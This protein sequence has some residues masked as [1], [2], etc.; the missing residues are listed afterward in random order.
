M[1]ASAYFHMCVLCRESLID[2]SVKGQY[3]TPMIRT[4]CLGMCRKREENSLKNAVMV[5]LSLEFVEETVVVQ[6]LP[7]NSANIIVGWIFSVLVSYFKAQGLR[8]IRATPVV[9]LMKF[10]VYVMFIFF[11]V[12][13]V[14]SSSSWLIG[15]N[16]LTSIVV[17]LNVYLHQSKFILVY[18]FVTIKF[19]PLQRNGEDKFRDHQ[20]CSLRNLPIILSRLVTGY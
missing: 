18:C 15:F 6:G 2:G 8:S 9:I 1:T 14:I 13:D 4:L 20:M 11:S 17:I 5:I 3:A 12:A 16:V 19:G 7:L 10:D